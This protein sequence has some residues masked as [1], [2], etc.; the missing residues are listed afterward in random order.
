[1][2]LNKEIS[3]NKNLS[4]D[5]V[6]LKVGGSVFLKDD[7]SSIAKYIIN[8]FKDSNLVVVVSAIGRSPYP[9]STDELLKNFNNIIYDNILNNELIKISKSFVISC[10]E[11]IS[12]GLLAA[13][14]NS[15]NNEVKAIPLNAFQAKIITTENPVDADIIDIEEQGILN[16]INNNYIP[17]VC[18]FQGVSLKGYLTTLK[19]GGSDITAAFL[20]K[21]LKNYFNLKGV[22][23]IKDIDS[24]K[25]APPNIINNPLPIDYCNYDELTEITYNGSQVV[26]ND[27]V[28]ILHSY[29]IPLIIKS[30]NSDNQTLV[31]NDFNSNRLIT[32]ISVKEDIV[33]F[34]LTFPKEK[35]DLPIYLDYI[36]TKINQKN[37]SLDF[38]ILDIF[39]R[40]ASF[41]V[42]K[43]Y[44][45]IISNI[46]DDFNNQLKDN[47]KKVDYK[48]LSKVS[49]VSIIGYGIRGKPGIMNRINKALLKNKIIILQAADSHISISLLIPSKYVKLTVE[50]IYN[51]FYNNKGS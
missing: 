26:H 32:N 25:S 9:Y 20:A 37:I 10:G 35:K 5:L 4:K 22:Y 30:I 27:A 12:A 41:V 39:N 7:I 43:N 19:R 40:K 11:N 36:L 49:K 38:I 13:A 21:K 17:I 34:S 31:S 33:K 8:K 24:L 14:I 16:L 1:M 45:K 44:Y 23:I 50:S 29:N 2:L 3:K 48:I 18:G 42:D 28:N 15:I 46:M 6:I 51:E 47:N